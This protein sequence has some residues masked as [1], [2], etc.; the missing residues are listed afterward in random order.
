MSR[1]VVPL[2]LDNLDDLP[3]PCR[4]CVFW[5]LEP[6][7]HAG[8]VAQDGGV[9]DGGGPVCRA[10]EQKES[11]VAETLLE[12]GTCGQLIYVDDVPA[13]YLLYAPSAYV[14]R[15]LSFA[16]APV[17]P[18]A[19]LLMT[20]QVRA[21]HAGGGSGRILMQAVARETMRHG[22][23]AIEAFAIASARARSATEAPVPAD[24]LARAP[25]GCLLPMDYLLSVG[26]KTVRPHPATPRLRLD[27]RRAITW[28]AD[29]E[30]ALERL[31]AGVS[32]PSLSP[33]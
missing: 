1:R 13:G 2:T 15:A 16:T 19:V 4:D 29:V 18:D 31:R 8:A 25:G 23:R 24:L 20:G 11:W 30:T 7:L 9:S 14:P 27:L 3:V 33:G 12:W 32:A 10:R 5:E 22:V 28:R 6:A 17:S 21:E 26:F